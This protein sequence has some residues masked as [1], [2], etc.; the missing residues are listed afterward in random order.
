M[1][2]TN[3]KTSFKQT[4]MK[5]YRAP[6][7][8]AIDVTAVSNAAPA[9]LDTADQTIKSG[10]VVYLQSDNP[11]ANGL[12]MAEVKTKG[13]ITL[14]GANFTAI[15]TVANAKLAVVEEM[16]Y[17]MAT[18]LN[19]DFGSIS[20][21]DV[22][23]NCDD[24]PQEEGEVQAGSYSGQAYSNPSNQV[25]ALMEDALFSQETLF[26]AWKSKDVTILRGSRIVV[27][28]FKLTGKT[29]EKW[30]ADFGFKMKSRPGR[31]AM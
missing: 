23:T 28:S 13:K 10:D 26:F 14:L 21:S 11:A 6:A 7:N 4:Q 24:Y 27:E 19:V 17:C 9:V 1:A 25:E 8:A 15:G 12:Y 29:K 31:L 22:T 16:A 2:D 20:Y 30:T 5:F 3:A 18:Q